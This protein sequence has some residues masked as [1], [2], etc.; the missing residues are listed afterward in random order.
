MESKVLFYERQRFRQWWVWT[1]LLIFIIINSIYLVTTF[2]DGFLPKNNAGLAIATTVILL[3]ILLIFFSHL[4]TKIKSDGIHIRFY[5]FHLK[6][7]NYPW[8][9]LKRVYVRRYAPLTE[10]GGWGVRLGMSMRRGRAFNVS[11]NKG[12]QLI[13]KNDKKLLIGT[14]K[15]EKVKEI[16]SQYFTNK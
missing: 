3:V 9:K 15:P 7:R 5:P 8:N 16:L 2:T 6:W 1:L 13:F 4:D 11:G 12:I 10:Y 14:Q